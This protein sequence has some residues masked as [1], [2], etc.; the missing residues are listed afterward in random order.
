MID[1]KKLDISSLKDKIFCG[2]TLKELENFKKQ[3]F[4]LPAS[5]ER[6][7]FIHCCEFNQLKHVSEKHFH[8]DSYF[9]LVLENSLDESL[10]YEGGGELF[11]H[12]YREINKSEVIQIIE[13]SR[14][15][16]KKFEVVKDQNKSV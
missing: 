15:D 9:L 5:F 8:E 14:I 7:H 3:G 12:L 13:I 4:H 1:F 6:E 11:P 2:I 10:K 16:T